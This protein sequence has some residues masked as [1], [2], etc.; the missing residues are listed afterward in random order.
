MKLSKEKYIDLAMQTAVITK[1]DGVF[2]GYLEGFKGVFAQGTTKRECLEELRSCAESWVEIRLTRRL[3]L[4][5]FG[6]Q[7][8]SSH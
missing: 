3:D 5:E 8:A 4:P 6:I 7:L 1:E 2:C